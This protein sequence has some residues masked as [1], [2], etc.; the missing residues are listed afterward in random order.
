[1]SDVRCQMSEGKDRCR[2][3]D[4]RCPMSDVR[5]GG[6]SMTEQIRSAKDLRVYKRAY[7]LSMEIFELSKAWPVEER[8][9]ELPI[10]HRTSDI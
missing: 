9:S 2:R 1:M 5:E 6:E 7:A 10:G 4:V 8:Y 3:S